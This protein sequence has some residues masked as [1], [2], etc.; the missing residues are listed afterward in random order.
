MPGTSSPSSSFSPPSTERRGTSLQQSQDEIPPHKCPAPSPHLPLRGGSPVAPRPARG[1]AE[2]YLEK[3]LN[4]TLDKGPGRSARR[5]LHILLSLL[6]LLSFQRGK[7]G[8]VARLVKTR[9]ERGRRMRRPM[10]PLYTLHPAP[11]TLHLQ[12]CTLHPTPS[13]FRI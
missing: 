11:Y 1:A 2:S 6:L 8:H 13:G 5:L 12:L 7:E 4:S 10:L 3:M 9:R